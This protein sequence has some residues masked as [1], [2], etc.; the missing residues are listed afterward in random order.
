MEKHYVLGVDFGSDSVRA[1]I[2]DA[3]TGAEIASSIAEYSR[4]RAGKYQDAQ[5]HMFRQHPLDYIEALTACVRTAVH[6]AGKEVQRKIAAVSVD[7]TGST[8]C[9]VNEMGVPLAL[10]PEFQEEPDAMFHLWKDHTAVAE[11]KEITAV[12]SKNTDGIDYTQFQ[13]SYASEWF[14]AKILHTSR[15]NP[16]IRESAYAWVEH[17]DWIPSLLCGN[18]RPETMYRCACAAGHK[19][20]WH[21]AWGG[22]PSER[23]LA[24]LDDCLVRVRRTY[25]T[26]PKPSTYCLG[27]ICADW[28]QRL[29]LEPDVLIGGSSFDAHAGAVGAG[30][31]KDTVVVNLGT[32]AVDMLVTDVK[33]LAS[34]QISRVCGMAENSII[35]GMVGLESG[36]AS[37]GDV[38]AWFS[39][40]L[41]WPLRSM[42]TNLL[43]Q[44]TLERLIGELENGLL[45]AL[46]QKAEAIDPED[47]PVAL[48][49]FNGRRYPCVNETVHSAISDVYMGTDAPTLYRALI[50]ATALGQRR[51]IEALECEGV[52]PSRIVA[53]GGIAQKSSLLMETL[54]NA[55]G[56]TVCVSKSKQACARGAAMYAAVAAGIYPNLSQ[57]QIHM[58]EEFQHVY[59]PDPSMHTRYDRIYDKYLQ[60]SAFI[61]P[62]IVI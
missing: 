49:W 41:M 40:L 60:L 14:W 34:G 52:A 21:S 55:L 27:S 43:P 19:A 42:P 58:C 32:S 33:S 10:L 13:G 51:I 53:V 57:A 5:K 30:V 18:T 61:D 38:Y 56:K 9:P 39:R 2:V 20:Y 24:Q 46:Q 37:F 6:A 8:P 47:A 44:D 3:L 25:G 22:L 29:G 45:P 28:A 11:A 62:N 16:K 12:F 48:D 59:V 36:Q 17:S 23:C 35:P 15:T 54:A 4:W 26:G 7:T 1:L 31:D 50:T